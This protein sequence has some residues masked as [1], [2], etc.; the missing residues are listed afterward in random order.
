M[1]AEDVARPGVPPVVPKLIHVSFSHLTDRLSRDL[2]VD[3][4]LDHGITVE[5]WD[6]V[7]LFREPYSVAGMEFPKYLRRFTTYRQLEAGVRLP[8]NSRALFL[9]DVAWGVKF[10]RLFRLFAKVHQPVLKLSMPEGPI[11]VVNRSISHRLRRHA[12]HPLRFTATLARVVKLTAYRRMGLVKRFA[13]CFTCGESATAA[14]QFAC[15]NIPVNTVDYDRFMAT[16]ERGDRLVNCPYA[17]FLDINLPFHDDLDLVGLSRLDP[18]EYY[19]SLNRFFTAVES[20]HGVRVVIAAHPTADY[21][22]DRFEGREVHRLETHRLVRDATFVLSHHSTSLGYA[23]LNLKPIIFV[24]TSAMMK[25]YRDNMIKWIT[26]NASFLDAAIYDTD[27]LDE[28]GITVKPVNQAT[29]ERYKY[30][31]LTTHQTDH[32]T[33]REIFLKTILRLSSA[34]NCDPHDRGSNHVL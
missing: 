31:F 22:S 2:Y 18:K 8:E 7:A 6:V 30:D 27:A 21:S 23:V 13:V 16:R 1:T 5:Y 3:I 28:S 20:A 19:D 25:L 15:V 17:V 4:L 32:S 29:Y 26:A 24:Y 12:R 33:T 11:R 14:D 34:T 10:T 9:L